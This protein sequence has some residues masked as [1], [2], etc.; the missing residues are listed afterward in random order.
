MSDEAETEPTLD[1]DVRE[2]ILSR[3]AAVIRDPETLQ[4]VPA[5]A[6]GLEILDQVLGGLCRAIPCA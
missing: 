4:E 2:T 3:P 5:G 1:G 6:I